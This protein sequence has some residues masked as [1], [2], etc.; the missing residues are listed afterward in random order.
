[1]VHPDDRPRIRAALQDRFR[2]GPGSSFQMEFRVRRADT[3]AERW[4]LALG[5]VMEA[6]AS[7]RFGRL[8]GVNLDITKRRAEQ[9]ALRESEALLRLAGRAAG[10]FAWDWDI[11][12]GRVTWTEG[13]EAALACRPAAS[14]AALKPSAPW[15]IPTMH[16]AWRLRWVA[17]ST[18]KPRNTVPT[19]ACAAPTEA[20]AGRRPGAPYCAMIWAGRPA[21]SAWITT[22]P[23]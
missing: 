23:T 7:G 17:P 13:L 2:D 20:C 21:W 11:A 5:R 4:L 8:M 6:G 14:A 15:F 19:F 16:R 18:A 22:S 3:G 12:S 9:E 1:M 10:V